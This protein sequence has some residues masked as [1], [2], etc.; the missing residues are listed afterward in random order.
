MHRLCHGCKLVRIEIL[1]P[2]HCCSIAV[3][4]CVFT[5]VIVSGRGSLI[6]LW[7]TGCVISPRNTFCECIIPEGDRQKI[8]M[9]ITHICT[10]TLTRSFRASNQPDVQAFGLWEE[11]REGHRHRLEEM[12]T[13]MSPFS[14]RG[15]F[16]R[17]VN[18]C[19]VKSSQVEDLFL[20]YAT[21]IQRL[22]Q[23]LKLN[24]QIK[25]K[26]PPF[27]LCWNTYTYTL[28]RHNM[29][30]SHVLYHNVLMWDQPVYTVMTALPPVLRGSQ[31]EQ[32]R[33][34]LLKG[35]FSRTSAHVVKFCYG[36]DLL[37]FCITTVTE[38]FLHLQLFRGLG[39]SLSLVTHLHH[40][41]WVRCL[42]H[43]E[44]PAHCGGFH[45]TEGRG[46]RKTKWS[47]Q[48]TR[49]HISTE[50][51]GVSASLPVLFTAS[52]ALFINR[53]FQL[54]LGGKYQLMVDDNRL[55]DLVNMGLT[56]HGVLLIWYG[57]QRGTKANS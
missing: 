57:H 25:I 27:Q 6:V 4:R 10:H 52:H 39:S 51:N 41:Y 15:C 9:S 37:Q 19:L 21:M 53:T 2:S 22:K 44:F 3:L 24:K 20:I 45:W 40:W 54:T 48:L 18:P 55:N 36:L 42:P 47:P 13:K 7:P 49:N 5:L 17:K 32:Q 29:S 38:N 46:V 35:K 26:S 8:L 14:E 33:R 43:P 23:K 28:R 16:F 56:G 50:S 1:P 30:H 11:T 31:V 34:P 12:C